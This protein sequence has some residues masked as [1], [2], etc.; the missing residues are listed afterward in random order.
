MSAAGLN[1][2]PADA[3]GSP[4]LFEP[5]FA[6][7]NWAL[8]KSVIKAASGERL[9]ASEMA[10]VRAVAGRDPPSCRV[11]EL[12]AIVGRGGGKDSIASLLATCSAINFN[13]AGKLRPGERA[14]V[15]CLACDREQAGIV[16]NYIKGLFEQVPSVKALAFNIGRESI[17]LRNGVSIEV[18]VA[19]FRGVRGRSLLCVVMDEAAF[20][21][22]D[23]SANPDQ[24]IYAAVG[25][26][27][28]RVPGSTLIMI[29]SAYKR[30]GLLYRKWAAHYGK[31]DDEV[32]VVRGTT[33]QFNPSFDHKIIE[34]ALAD[35]RERYS[36]EYLSEWRDDLSSFIGL[37]AS[38]SCR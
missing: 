16:F 35:D 7:A 15:M 22:S 1:I 12:V 13:P 9:T 28:A 19:S 30:S 38:R 25:P 6:G 18:H 23:E 4:L 32:L 24:Q 33:P 29:S 27:L 36:A 21:R 26:G 8:W 11:R 3:M 5:F 37:G 31:N 10:A 34:R 20:W 14:I 2:S 17:D